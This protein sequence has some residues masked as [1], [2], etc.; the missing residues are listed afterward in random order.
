MTPAANF[1]LCCADKNAVAEYFSTP[2]KF[3]MDVEDLRLKK[4]VDSFFGKHNV[5]PTIAEINAASKGVYSE[6]KGTPLFF[7]EQL[8]NYY[9]NITINEYL[10]TIAGMLGGKTTDSADIPLS[11]V[12][13]LL[14]KASFELDANDTPYSENVQARIDEYIERAKRGGVSYISTGDALLDSLFYGY[15]KSDLVTIGARSG[16]GK[17]FFLNVL[18]LSLDAWVKKIRNGSLVFQSVVDFNRPILFVS[19]EMTEMDI[20]ERLDALN[21]KTS[22]TKLIGA[23]LSRTEFNKYKKDLAELE[24]VK[25]NIV[26]CS[27]IDTIDQLKLKIAIYNPIAVFI[28]ASYLMYSEKEDSPS[29]TALITR[30][31]KGLSLANGIPIIHTLQLKKYSGKEGIKKVEAQDE[32]PHTSIIQDSDLV[33]RLYATDDLAFEGFVGADVPKI[34]RA[35]DGSKFLFQKK[36]NSMDFNIVDYSVLGE[37]DLLAP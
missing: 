10:V 15:A 1:V 6:V 35:P 32:F 24:K 11:K 33:I 31:L 3:Y 4:F 19:N 5:F 13:E 17:T 34:R 9:L 23:N 28:D 2:E 20:I 8:R 21:F 26:V 30:G 37:D 36:F 12:Q 27:K 22:Y 29:K 25:S 18:C 16:V 7:K 14:N